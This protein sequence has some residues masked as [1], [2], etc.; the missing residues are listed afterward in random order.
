M[1]TQSHTE[2]PGG[3]SGGFPPFQK[4]TCASQLVWLAITFVLLYVVMAKVALPRVGAIIE[5]RR[6]RIDGDLATANRLK[7]S[8]D[9]AMSAYEKALIEARNRAQ[10]L[11]AETRDRLNAEAEKNRKAL[12][13][14]L[15]VKLAEAEKT[16]A[17]TKTQAMT[18]VRAIA[19]D[20]AG[21][22][23][24]RLTGSAPSDG[25]VSGAVDAVLKR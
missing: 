3:H 9:E 20:A 25:A 8:A 23:V 7:V 11:A 2:A 12:D 4:D 13:E 22:I 1:A 16:I 21:A 6:S 24:A 15:N 10:M 14:Q 19:I 18:N 17:A 5:A